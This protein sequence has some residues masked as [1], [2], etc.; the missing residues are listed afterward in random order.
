M[1]SSDS[2]R[3]VIWTLLSDTVR[4]KGDGKAVQHQPLTSCLIT[5]NQHLN[6]LQQSLTTANATIA[7]H[8]QISWRDQAA[9]FP[10]IM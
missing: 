2:I 9:L 6:T 3:V 1:S 4:E 5:F 8:Q 7:T 10:I